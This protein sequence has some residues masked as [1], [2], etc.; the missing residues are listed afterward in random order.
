[1]A[2]HA[3]RAAAGRRLYLLFRIGEDRYALEAGGVAEVLG[4]RVLKQVPGAPASSA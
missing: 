3:P 4:L 1:M 2:D